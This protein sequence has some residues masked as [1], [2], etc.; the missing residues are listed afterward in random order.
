MI[1]ARIKS[2]LPELRPSERK[3]AEYVLAQPNLTT[4]ASIKMIAAAAGASEPTVIRFCR[5][6]GCVGVQDLKRQIARD[7]G[8]LTPE[9]HP[10]FA[11]GD[12]FQMLAAALCDQAFSSVFALRHTLATPL[13]GHAARRLAASSR[14]WIWG[15]GGA[16]SIAAAG[17]EA[18][19]RDDL[20][21]R[22]SSDPYVQMD[23]AS[24]ATF[25]TTALLI[26]LE[27]ARTGQSEALLAPARLVKAAGG[28]ILV[29]A[30]SQNPLTALAHIALALPAADALAPL[31]SPAP[32]F[33]AQL[34]LDA[35]RLGAGMARA[36]LSPRP[37][38]A[39]G[40]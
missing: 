34:L 6:I 7:L 1:I 15:F 27:G 5:A 30:P 39:A 10:A 8:R 24:A 35:L 20:P 37:A 2:L 14:I 29:L 4:G 26:S 36:Q 25:A 28:T 31:G 9:H 38:A 33:A 3:V 40:A 18:F 19:A 13:L 32:R 12:P 16:A 17:A 21:A 23:E 11:P 22:A